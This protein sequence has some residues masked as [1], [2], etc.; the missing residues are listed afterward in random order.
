MNVK[1]LCESA[2]NIANV[3]PPYITDSISAIAKI[4]PA[5]YSKSDVIS[6]PAEFADT[7]ILFS[8]WGMPQ[9][10]AEE[11]RT[12]LPKLKCVFYGA[13][14]VQAFARPFLECGVKVFSAW[15]DL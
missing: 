15:V 14:T 10:S 12:Y 3:F 9:F 8:T 6:A 7:E 13:G 4:D 2:E 1:F 5:P 11:I